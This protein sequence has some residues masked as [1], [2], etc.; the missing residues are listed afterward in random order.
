M[1]T[2]FFLLINTQVR[3]KARAGAG[4]VTIH[5]QLL[6][7]GTLPE[8]CP[9]ITQIR[10]VKSYDIRKQFPT[11]DAIQNIIIK[12]GGQFV[13]VYTYLSVYSVYE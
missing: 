8:E 1:P 13:Q 9:S 3:E 6:L 2:I 4:P 5:K 10:N 12:Y 11:A 7:E